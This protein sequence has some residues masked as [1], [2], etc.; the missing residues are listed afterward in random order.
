VASILVVDDEPEIRTLVGQVLR[1]KGYAVLTAA[2]GVEALTRISEQSPDAIVLDLNMPV[3]DGAAFLSACRCDP[4]NANVPVALFTTA[5]GGD[6]I[7]E[8]LGVHAYVPKPFDIQ[9]LTEVVGRLV[10]EFAPVRARAEAGPSRVPT[11]TSNTPV[12]THH[13]VIRSMRSQLV[14]LRQ[15]IQAT[16]RT[17]ERGQ[18]RVAGS[19]A[20]LDRAIHRMQRSRQLVS[21]STEPAG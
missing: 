3:M 7:A 15:Q 4:L 9:R 5:A 1:E 2:N 12:N 14:A 21:L 13:W 17:I 11:T 18:D 6:V 10:R 19:N 16:R 20:C 8:N